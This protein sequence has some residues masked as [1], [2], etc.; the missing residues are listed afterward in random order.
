MTI[1]NLHLK[2]FI[3]KN[4][5]YLMRRNIT[6]LKNIACNCFEHLKVRCVFTLNS[7]WKNCLRY[8]FKPYGSCIFQTPKQNFDLSVWVLIVA[9]LMR[10]D[11][12]TRAGADPASK[13]RGG[14]FSNIW[15]S[16]LI[17]VHC[18]KID[19]VY[20]STLLWQNNGRQNRLI[21][22]MLFFEL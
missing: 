10:K 16:T 8:V 3:G 6:Y 19:E 11:V 1:T 17:T 20:F 14:D 18:C 21:S 4:W 12:F 15:H 22:R 7:S 2:N 5:T 13:F 9:E